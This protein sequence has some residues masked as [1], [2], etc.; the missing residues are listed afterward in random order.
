M[1]SGQSGVAGRIQYHGSGHFPRVAVF[2]DGRPIN[3]GDDLTQLSEDRLTIYRKI[4][5]AMRVRP[6]EL[7]AKELN[8]DVLILNNCI[9][10]PWKSYHVVDVF[11]TTE[12]EI[13]YALSL[14]C[15]GKRPGERVLVYDFWNERFLGV[16]DREVLLTIPPYASVVLAIRS[17]E[18]RPQLVSV[19]R[20]VL[21]GAYEITN[22]KWEKETLS[23]EVNVVAN[24]EC[25]LRFYVPVGY[26]LKTTKDISVNQENGLAEL[27]VIRPESGNVQWKLEF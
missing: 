15:I 26:L 24:A 14:N 10:N 27:T 18:G 1:R 7:K 23:G 16:C 11:N 12:H 5:P 3:V 8:T 21:Q 22:M 17:D 25:K 19:S 2:H 20:H 9:R 13:Q 6:T 4:L